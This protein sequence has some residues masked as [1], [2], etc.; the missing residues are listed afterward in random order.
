MINFDDVIKK[1]TYKKIS[2]V[3][4]KFLTILIS[5]YRILIVGGSGSG[6]TN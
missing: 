6:I 4:Q 1:T 3:G 5:L 2:Q